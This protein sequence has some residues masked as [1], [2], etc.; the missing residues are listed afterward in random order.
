VVGRVG[1]T[2]AAGRAYDTIPGMED[3][4]LLWIPVGLAFILGAVI[5]MFLLT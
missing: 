1:P 2:P 4:T 5:L 3:L